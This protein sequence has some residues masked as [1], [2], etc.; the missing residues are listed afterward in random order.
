VGVS[1]IFS[2]VNS[3]GMI[4]NDRYSKILERLLSWP[5]SRT[6]YFL[7]KILA[8]MTI[9]ISLL[10]FVLLLGMGECPEVGTVSQGNTLGEAID[11]LKE[12]TELYLEEFPQKEETLITTFEVSIA[13]T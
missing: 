13:K 12:A 6:S 11:N 1:I 2:G 9:S 7:S 10:L 3:G 5:I 4:S 8:S